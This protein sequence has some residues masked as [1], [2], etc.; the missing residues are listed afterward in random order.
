MEFSPMRNAWQL[1]RRTADQ[2]LPLVG[3]TAPTPSN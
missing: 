1:T 3:A 2:L